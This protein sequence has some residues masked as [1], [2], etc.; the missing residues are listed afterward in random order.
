M[1]PSQNLHQ[2]QVSPSL[3]EIVRVGV[4]FLGSLAI[5]RGNRAIGATIEAIGEELRRTIGS[6]RP[7]DLEP[8]ARSRR[9]YKLVGIDPTKDRPSSERLLRRVLLRHGTEGSVDAGQAFPRVND[10]VDAMNLVSLRLQFPLGYYDWDRIAP[11]VLLRIGRP[12]ESY[13]GIGGQRVNL[14]G[15]IV[16]VDGEGSFGNPTRD[17]GR[18]QITTRTV[19]A[20]VVGFAPHDAPRA[21]FE[22]LLREIGAAAE[23]YCGGRV[24]ASGLLPP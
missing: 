14:Q 9:L 4:V 12:D 13:P 21:A 5:D 15:K 11:P 24:T 19:R 16:L 8:V 23:A 2:V 17:S 7:A 3:E 22:E 20:L 1:D 6:R 10:F 18:S